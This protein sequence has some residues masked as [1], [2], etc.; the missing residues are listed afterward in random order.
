MHTKNIKIDLYCAKHYWSRSSLQVRGSWWSAALVVAASTN[1]HDERASILW[2]CSTNCIYRQ[3]SVD[4]SRALVPGLSDEFKYALVAGAVTGGGL[5]I[6]ANAP[7]P[8]GIAILRN[9]FD[10]NNCQSDGLVSCCD[11]ANACG[12]F[13]VQVFVMMP[14]VQVEK[15]Q[16]ID[17]FISRLQSVFSVDLLVDLLSRLILAL[18]V[19]SVVML[20]WIIINRLSVIG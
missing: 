11:P 1:K 3:C 2:C 16:L 7:N 15:R 10:D 17:Q 20:T 19:F 6:I 14:I 9:H 5:T 12:R 18:V 4:I 13:C 8:A